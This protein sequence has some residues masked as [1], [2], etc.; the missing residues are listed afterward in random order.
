M[1]MRMWR[2]QVRAGM[3]ESYLRYLESTGLRDYGATPGN[4]GVYATTRPLGDN[5]EFVLVT[6]WESTDA[7]RNFA[8]EPVERAI[9][10]PE[11]DRF[12]LRRAET[13]EHYE[14]RYAAPQAAALAS[15]AR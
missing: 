4:R 8:G 6:F 1:I 10:Y 13:V 3:A 5:V 14:V 7:I 9:Y 2:G 11:D 15:G 12:L